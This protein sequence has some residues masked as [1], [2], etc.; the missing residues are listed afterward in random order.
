MIEDNLEKTRRPRGARAKADP[1]GL[2]EVLATIFNIYFE[3]PTPTK[4]GPFAN[5][6]R[7]THEALRLHRKD[8][9]RGIAK[10]LKSY[11]KPE[12]FGGPFKR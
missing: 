9:S 11:L 8:P 10:A 1:T 12:P 4:D 2:I 7:I 5:V 3:K 6:V